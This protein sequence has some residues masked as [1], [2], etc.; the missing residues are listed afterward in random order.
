MQI[1]LD[2]SDLKWTI[3]TGDGRTLTLSH[4]EMVEMVS[5]AL[6]FTALRD[7]A[8]NALVFSVVNARI[9]E[10]VEVLRWLKG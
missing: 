9:D 2:C 4:A 8:T 10:A 3:D 5:K 7:E 6:S 1:E